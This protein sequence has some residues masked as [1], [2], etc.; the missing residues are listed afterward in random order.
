MKAWLHAARAVSLTAVLAPSIAVL[1][2]GLMQDAAVDIARTLT[3]LL[4]VSALLLGVNMQTTSKTICAASTA[5]DRS[6]ALA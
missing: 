4:G 1:L 3:A 6:G 5:W 2:A